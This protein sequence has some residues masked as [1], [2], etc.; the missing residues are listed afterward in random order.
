[1]LAHL[2]AAYRFARWLCRDPAD[3]EDV[4]H[5]AVVRAWRAWESA[6]VADPRSWLLAIVRNCHLSALK[7]RRPELAVREDSSDVLE[8]IPSTLPTPLPFIS[9]RH[10]PL[11]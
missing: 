6:R 8:R 7:A 11:A 3:A 4:V 2:D 1:M 9:A 5:D 10:G